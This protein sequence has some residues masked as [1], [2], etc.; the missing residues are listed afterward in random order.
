MTDTAPSPFG[1]LLDEAAE[2]QG[3]AVRLRRALH[4]RP[5]IGL[6]LPHTQE[7]VLDALRKCS[8]SPAFAAST[9][10]QKSQR[11]LAFRLWRT[12]EDSNLRPPDS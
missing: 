5:E 9:P 4:V 6:Q 11:W 7:R 10:K 2:L 8:P 12:R 3:E 1:T